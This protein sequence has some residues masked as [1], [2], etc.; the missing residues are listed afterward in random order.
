MSVARGLDTLPGQSNQVLQVVRRP[1]DRA[2]SR[3]AQIQARVRGLLRARLCRRETFRV[4][5]SS[6]RR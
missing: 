6:C 4:S 5:S 1:S 2:E 3:W